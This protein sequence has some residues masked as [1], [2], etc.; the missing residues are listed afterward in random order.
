MEKTANPLYQTVIS[1]A[2][3][4]ARDTLRTRNIH[5][6]I[7]DKAELNRQVDE[8]TKDADNAFKDAKKALDVVNYKISKVDEADPEAKEKLEVLGNQ[9]EDATKALNRAEDAQKAALT[10]K[11]EVGLEL[12]K[13]D[14]R[15]AKWETG[16]SKVQLENLN[17]LAREYVELAFQEKAKT[18][19]Q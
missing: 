18:L 3:E 10:F 6:L 15:I 17:E 14:E 8:A 19:A 12:S 7:R 9:L 13:I 1:G 16:E 2:R 5:K 11:N 4:L